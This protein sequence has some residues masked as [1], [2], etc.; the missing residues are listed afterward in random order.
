MGD[1]L[2]RG[3]TFAICQDG[4]ERSNESSN[5]AARHDN[6]SYASFHS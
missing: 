2:S 6:H 1:N 5:D 3:Q 4:K